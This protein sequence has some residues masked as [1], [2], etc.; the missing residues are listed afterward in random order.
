MGR[1]FKAIC[2]YS[3]AWPVDRGRLSGVDVTAVRLPQSRDVWVSDLLWAALSASSPQPGD[4]WV[5]GGDFNLCETFDS[6]HGGPRG[7][8]EF[9]DRMDR[10]GLTDCLRY[11][12]GTLTPTFCT[13]RKGTVTAQID[14]LFVTDILRAGMVSCDTGSRQRVFEE[15]ISDHLP[16]IADFAF[17][18]VDE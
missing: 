9:L 14:Y 3:P 12:R 11:A 7:N 10:L 5:I 1:G 17:V 15:R 8:R 18:G 4:Y 16:I 13:V 6:W 2:V